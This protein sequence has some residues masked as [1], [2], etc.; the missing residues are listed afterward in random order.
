MTFLRIQKA[1]KGVKCAFNMNDQETEEY[2]LF[3]RVTFLLR[4]PW[5][6]IGVPYKVEVKVNF[7]V[8]CVAPQESKGKFHCSLCCRKNLDSPIWF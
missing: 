6:I 4:R 2:R 1:I 3:F 5:N 7:L 8:V